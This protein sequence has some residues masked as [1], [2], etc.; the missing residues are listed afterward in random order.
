MGNSKKLI[1]GY[2]LCEDYSQICCYSYKTFEPIPIGSSE[3]ENDTLIPTALCVNKDTRIWLYGKDAISCGHDG[4]GILIDN[5]LTKLKNKEE[6]KVFGETYSAVN[7]L[8]KFLR[9]TITLIKDYFP[10]EIITQLVVTVHELDSSIVDG[11]YEALHLLGIDKDRVTVMSHGS[12]FMYYAL[13]QDRELWLNDVGLFDFH[14]EGLSYYQISIN[15]RIKPMIA[16]MEKENFSDTFNY[17]VIKENKVDKKFTFENIANTLLYKQIVTTLYFTGK[18]FEGEWAN[19]SIRSL[20]AGRRVFMGQNLYVKG[21]CYGAKELSGDRK[22]DNIILLNNDM[23]VNS[24]TIR[25][26]LDGIIQEVMLTDATIPWYEVNSAVE[27]ILDDALDM[28]IIFRNIMTKGIIRER[29]PLNAPPERSNRMTRLKLNLSCE[30]RNKAKLIITDLGFG[31]IYP[32]A[33]KV[34]EY[35]MDMVEIR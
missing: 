30:D 35:V 15:R 20:C 9:K 11:I 24:V 22:L 33:G 18:G 4:S 34:A 31:D 10:T 5:L 32:A 26:Y 23:I 16:K 7:M 12:S 29:I 13:S 2:D 28:E 27:V 3:D 25:A 8:E 21:A 6:I 1:V 19:D 14:R 17:K